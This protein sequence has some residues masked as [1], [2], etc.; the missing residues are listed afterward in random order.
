MVAGVTAFGRDEGVDDWPEG[1]L[2]DRNRRD[3][4]SGIDTPEGVTHPAIGNVG[5]LRDVGRCRRVA[6]E[7]RSG[8]R[9]VGPLALAL[10]NRAED[11]IGKPLSHW[12][13][14][15]WPSGAQA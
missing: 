15:A 2:S 11:E 3:T 7:S 9:G 6:L 4:E 12:R 1:F 5:V 10:V 8:G 14:S 13:G